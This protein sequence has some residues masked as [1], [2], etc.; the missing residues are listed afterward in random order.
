MDTCPY[1]AAKDRGV[2]YAVDSCPESSDRQPPLVVVHQE[3]L[4]CILY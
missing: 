1:S 2:R 4:T 3:K